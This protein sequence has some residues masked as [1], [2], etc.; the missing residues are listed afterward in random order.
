MSKREGK[1]LVSKK[2]GMVFQFREDFYGIIDATSKF[3]IVEY[4]N[5]VLVSKNN[6]PVNNVVT[7]EKA[8]TPTQE[9]TESLEEE[10][11]TIEN[12]VQEIKKKKK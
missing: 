5:G 9:E 12:L 6:K 10:D 3:D 8:E 4:K 11:S 2:N 7:V 1:F